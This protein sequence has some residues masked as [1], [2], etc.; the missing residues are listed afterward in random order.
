VSL[1]PDASIGSLAAR[2]GRC[3]SESSLSL[4]CAESCTGG[5]LSY[6]LTQVPGASRWFDRAH[7][8]YA[9]AAKHDV[10]G[11]D[12]SVL[13]QHGAVSEACA[14][15]MARGTLGSLDSGMAVA[16]TGIAGPDGG[17]PDKPV[18]LVWLAWVWTGHGQIHMQ[19]RHYHF[20]GDREAIR[21]ASIRAALQ[22]ILT[23]LGRDPS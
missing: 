23:C 21:L 22:G 7:V 14:L 18:G 17:T 1:L 3:L 8:V 12:A 10:L 5:G 9:N 4:R 6:A 19:A 11:V 2:V 20:D 16:V 13:E 15:A